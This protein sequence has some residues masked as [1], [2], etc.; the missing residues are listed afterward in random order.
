[1]NRKPGNIMNQRLMMKGA[2]GFRRRCTT[3]IFICVQSGTF[4]SGS[5]SLPKSGFVPW[6]SFLTERLAGNLCPSV[7]EYV[8]NIRKRSVGSR[9]IAVAV[10]R[11]CVIHTFPD[12]AFKNR[13]KFESKVTFL[14]SAH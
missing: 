10:R 5:R 3:W 4:F 13:L 1:M 2:L 11:K 6:E 9:I 12:I 7:F 8:A 14:K